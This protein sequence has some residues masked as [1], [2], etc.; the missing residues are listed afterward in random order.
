MTKRF[1]QIIIDI[2][3]EKVDR[4]FD[5]RIPP[6][7]EDRISV[8]VL[9]KIPFGKGNSL[10]KGYVVGI[11][12]HAD[13]DA[14]KIKEIAGIVEG[15]VSAESQLIMLAWWLK[16]QYGS[17]MNQALKTVLPV[18]QKVKPKEKKVLRLLI[19]E[20]QLEAVTAE[21][22]KKSY[23]AR[24]RLFKALKENPLIPYEVASGQMN[25][26]A[27]TLKPVIEKGYVALESEEIFRN[28][29]KDAG[30]RVKAV[31]LNGEQQAVVDAFCEDYE[32]GKRETYLIHGITGSG[33]TEVY[34]EMISRVISE[35][36][37][38]I[39]LIP[40]I[41]LTYQTVM[42]FY[43]RF[44]NRVSIIN[45]RLSAGERY[46]Q[47]ERARGGDIDIMIGPRSALFTPF[48]RL[49]LIIID[50]EHEGAYK[51]EVVPRYHAREVAVKRA[52]M[53]NASV[54]LG[55]ATPSLEAYTKALRG[56]Y[57]L[58][59]LH[60][61]AKADSRLADVAVV[62]LR[63]EL[64]A[65]NK[66]IFSRRLQQMI[67]DRLEKKEQIMM[68][69]NRRGYA[70]FVSCRSCGE[71][72]K[73][74]HCDVTLTLHKDNRLVC[75]YCGYSIPMPDK[76]PSCGSPYIANFGVGTQKIEMMTKKMF[77]QARVLRMD[78]DTT[79][80]KGGHEE[81]LS[82]F[83]EGDADI[84]IGTQMIVKGH[85]FPD[86]TL[87]GV[88]AADLSLYTPDYRAAERTFQLLTQA[89]GRAGRDARHGDVI[90][91][92][93]NPEHYSIVTAAEQDYETFYHQEMAYRRLMKYP[94]VNVLFTVQMASKSEA[95]LVEAADRLAAHITPQADEEKVQ[96]IGPVDASV[97]K[98]NDIYRKILYLKQE[99]YDILIKIRDNIDCF[100][101]EKSEIFKGVVVQYDFS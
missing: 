45:S 76:C 51:S 68:F 10:R 16:E 61:R 18:K 48:S 31:D 53:Q 6:Q 40:E 59:S 19:P 89:A 1:A 67:G 14:D 57:R 82:A 72:I 99:N 7:L 4:T 63:E 64:K 35:G 36:K 34:M 84:L 8:G 100:Q 79:S 91:Q 41:A 98:I 74:P 17:T 86:V 42:R 22:E 80:K 77:P 96:M 20:E 24:V 46:D 32:A 12:D 78:L 3:H 43:G 54:V 58:F 62:D 87:V 95:A 70:N 85:D 27:A 26:S 60:T 13:Y 65:G 44:G 66:S 11:T 37:Q 52:Q 56:E 2:S 5:Y 50:E 39:V 101:Q 83:A 90:I 73:C 88:L 55:S 94:P 15:S 71:A 92:T 47:F 33:K 23:K 81:I 49:G 75:H 30:S 21:A 25:L 38:V 97:Y 29:V 28:P 93:Y 69:I 9:V